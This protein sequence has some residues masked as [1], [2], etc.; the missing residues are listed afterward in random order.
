MNYSNQID[1]NLPRARVVELFDNVD[2]LKHWMPGLVHFETYE[3][4]S[5]KPGAKSRMEF[6]MGKRKIKMT[7]TIVSNNLPDEME[8]YY[9]TNGMKN[10]IK[11]SFVEIEPNK[12]MYISEST[13]KFTGVMWLIAPLMKKTFMKTSQDYLE[14]FKEF[15]E[16]KGA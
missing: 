15:A 5:G 6:Q 4:Q 14:R 13:F 7:E 16:S 12:T 11:V 9:E 1:I 10:D 8:G 3:G 2:N